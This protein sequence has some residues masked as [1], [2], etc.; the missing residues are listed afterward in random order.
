[1]AASFILPKGI[2]LVKETKE[3]V[4]NTNL[5]YKVNKNCFVFSPISIFWNANSILVR[6]PGYFVCTSSFFHKHS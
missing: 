2:K 5:K 1:M 6:G 4:T 3:K